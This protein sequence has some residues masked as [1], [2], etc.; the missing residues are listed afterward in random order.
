MAALPVPG[1]NIFSLKDFK[2]V[3]SGDIVFPIIHGTNGEDGT[4]QGILE[5]MEIPYVGSGVCGSA[6]GM[7][8]L[9]MK[10]ILK[11]HGVPQVKYIGI[12]SKE[13]FENIEKAAD[14][15]LNELKMPYL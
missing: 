15:I 12:T 2:P 7:D 1:R 3:F 11:S 5:Y 10:D 13:L 4:L 9:I 14:K 8:K 6:V